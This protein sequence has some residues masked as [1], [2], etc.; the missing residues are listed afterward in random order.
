MIQFIHGMGG[1]DLSDKRIYH[2]AVERS[3]CRYWKKILHN[4]MDKC[5]LNSF[6]FLQFEI[7]KIISQEQILDGHYCDI[8]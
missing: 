8:V 1:V 6:I 2:Y 4:I 5:V 3:T 7:T